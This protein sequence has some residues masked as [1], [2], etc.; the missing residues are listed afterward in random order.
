MRDASR[1]GLPPHPRRLLRP[2]PARPSAVRPAPS[3]PHSPTC[4]V[5]ARCAPVVRVRS[6]LAS[7][8]Q[9]T[10][11]VTVRPPPS[12]CSGE[13]C[14]RCGIPPG[15]AVGADAAA[16]GSSC[17][18]SAR[19]GRDRACCLLPSTMPWIR[20]P[21]LRCGSTRQLDGVA[22]RTV[23]SEREGA[24]VEGAGS[25]GYDG[26]GSLSRWSRRR[27]ERREGLLPHRR[28]G[29]YVARASPACPHAA[30]E[31]HR[32]QPRARPVGP[33]GHRLGGAVEEP[34]DGQV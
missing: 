6:T 30:R 21:R 12:G 24:P 2:R 4:R 32:R 13:G 23:S 8:G 5:D 27:A 25:G 16:R 14:V 9:R 7:D 17:D 20:E 11:G 19:R 34:T 18:V 22:D 3:Q 10:S 29:S 28:A 33:L 1:R 31:L 15:L 26:Q